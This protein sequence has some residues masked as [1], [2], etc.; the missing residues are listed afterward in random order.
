MNTEGTWEAS[1]GT[2]DAMIRICGLDDIAA[3]EFLGTRSKRI[4]KLRADAMQP[5]AGTIEALS[6]LY[7]Q[8][9][10]MADAII[11]GWDAAG[12][13][14]EMD[15]DLG[16]MK[17]EAKALG[18]PE[19]AASV[20]TVAMAQAVLFPARLSIVEGKPDGEE[21]PTEPVPNPA[22]IAAE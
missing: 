21:D 3:A 7:E 19:Y 1:M 12:R 18:W 11:E 22:A 8:Q 20:T 5:T 17:G 16:A 6:K 4:R 13:P 9:Q 2:F 15:V 10:R 14:P